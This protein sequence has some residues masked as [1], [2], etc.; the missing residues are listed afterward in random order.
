MVHPWVSHLFV[1]RKK[2][3]IGE[4]SSTFYKVKPRSLKHCNKN[5]WN[6][7]NLKILF[8]IA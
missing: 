4:T 5:S 3:R 7:A 1:G 6:I 2:Y 8:P